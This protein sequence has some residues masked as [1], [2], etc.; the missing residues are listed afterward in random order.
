MGFRVH[1]FRSR[2]R[3]DIIG[4]E[5]QSRGIK[6]GEGMTEGVS[7]RMA[8]LTGQATRFVLNSFDHAAAWR[9]G[10]LMAERAL[11]ENAPIIIDIRTPTMVLFRSALA[12]TT[13]ENEVWLERKART[14]FRFETST[15]LLAARFAA[16]GV[17]L[18]AVGW[19]D[20]ERFTDAGGSFPLRVR[21][22]GV[23]A[24]VT[25]S[26]LTSD[27]DHDF[28]IDGLTQYIDRQDLPS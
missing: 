22:V 6:T 3:K 15:A 4:A 20:T 16:R 7:D 18:E 2:R 24:A 23:V 14:V 17:D 19:F 26:G 13:A 8:E 28:V 5:N 9:L 12:G 21:G 1:D 10:T 25:V 11:R 27:E